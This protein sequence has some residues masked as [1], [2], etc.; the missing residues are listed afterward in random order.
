MD[1]RDPTDDPVVEEEIVVEVDPNDVEPLVPPAPTEE[2]QST[3]RPDFARGQED[4]PD[5]PE[6]LVQ[7][8]FARG[9]HQD[10]PEHEQVH[11]GEFADG[12]ETVKHHPEGKL[13]GR[14]SKGQERG[15][16]RVAGD[17]DDV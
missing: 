13:H 16:E 4:L 3:A 7:P 8:D 15:D 6:R 17:P 10:L 14:F 11:E 1:H 2:P 12:Q 5:D 9:Q